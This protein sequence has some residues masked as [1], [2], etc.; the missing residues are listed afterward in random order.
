MQEPKSVQQHDV[1]EILSDSSDESEEE[2]ENLESLSDTQLTE[3]LEARKK[4]LE[5]LERHQKEKQQLI[6][7]TAKWKNVG[8]EAL[9]ILEGYFKASREE[10]LRKMGLDCEAFD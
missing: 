3:L 9:E 1:I 5:V 7:Y 8:N 2:S 10:L 6:E 4:Q